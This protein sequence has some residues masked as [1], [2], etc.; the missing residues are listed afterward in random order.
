MKLNKNELLKKEPDSRSKI[1][2]KKQKQKQSYWIKCL[3]AGSK[4]FLREG[5]LLQWKPA[6]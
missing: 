1:K 2:E 3:V 4:P 5:F 6:K